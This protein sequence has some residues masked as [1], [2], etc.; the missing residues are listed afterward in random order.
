MSNN[1]KKIISLMWQ[2]IFV[3]GSIL[4]DKKKIP[5]GKILNLFNTYYI[6]VYLQ[7][8]ENGKEIAQ[9]TFVTLVYTMFEGIPVITPLLLPL[10]LQFDLLSVSKAFWFVDEIVVGW[11]VVGVSDAINVVYSYTHPY[12]DSV[13]WHSVSN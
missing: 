11:L 7:T 12:Q 2:M 8:K 6:T 10:H 9:S 3:F 5:S 4:D 1:Q 13:S